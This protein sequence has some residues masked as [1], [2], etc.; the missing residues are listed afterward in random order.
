M[1]NLIPSIII[2][3]FL[4][5]GINTTY[6]Q[7]YS[8]VNYEYQP[9]DF[10][11]QA[12]I[13]LVSTFVSPNAKTR[14]P[15]VSIVLNYRVKQHFS[16]GAYFGYSSTGY[17]ALDEKKNEASE[18]L[19]LVNNFYLTGLRAEGHWNKDRVDFYG[20]AMLGYNFS[21]ID[22]NITDPLSRPEG[23]TI[24]DKSNLM[25]YSGYMGIR[26]A[27]SE[28]LGF[29]GELGYGASLVNLGLSFRL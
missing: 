1:K 12:G 22:T 2:A 18:K 15:P 4:I 17:T 20:G 21:K 9:G 28:Q 14:I 25:T 8:K 11:L 26:Y 6:A 5:T 29:Y 27:A 13:G 16:L 10:E 24:E 19:Y 3:L 7:R 23:I